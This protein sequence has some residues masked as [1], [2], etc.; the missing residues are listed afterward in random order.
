MLPFAPNTDGRVLLIGWDAVDWGA[1][2]STVADDLTPHLAR[3]RAAGTFGRL[4]PVRPLVAPMLWTSLA[5]GTRADKHGV[6]GFCEPLPDGRGIIP[7]RSTRRRRPAIWDYATAAGVPSHVVGWPVTAPADAVRGVMVSDGYFR[8]E[9]STDDEGVADDAVTVHPE[10]QAIADAALRRNTPDHMPSDEHRSAAKQLLDGSSGD[11]RWGGS[12]AAGLSQLQSLHAIAFSLLSAGHWQFAAVRYPTAAA[13]LPGDARDE[14]HHAAW[15]LQD[16]MLGELVR[17][18]GAETTVILVSPARMSRLSVGASHPADQFQAN[19][20]NA[21]GM[22]CVTGP[23]VIAA[24]RLIGATVLDVAP[25]VLDRLGF[26]LPGDLDGRPWLHAFAPRDAGF[27]R[28]AAVP[29]ARFAG[30]ALEAAAADSERAASESPASTCGVE[31]DDSSGRQACAQVLHNHKVN[32]AEALADSDRFEQALR[33]WR[34]L[35]TSHPEDPQFAVQLVRALLRGGRHG[36]CAEVIAQLPPA[37]QTLWPVQLG[38]AEIAAAKQRTGEAVALA[39][40]VVERGSSPAA[41]LAAA[42]IL[43]NC[44]AWADAESAYQRHLDAH[45][46]SAAAYG[47]LARA[48]WQQER[49]ELAREA[50]QAALAL[51]PGYTEA[52]LHMALALRELDRQDD[53]IREFERCV[54]E[55]W[56]IEVAHGQLA[57]LYCTRSPRRAAMHRALA[58]VG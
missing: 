58:G 17:I 4:A 22:A 8:G 47:G 6:L 23:E 36:E 15:R 43:E 14:L 33:L 1:V 41:L 5:T 3:M 10:Y 11:T 49:P 16:A 9:R 13:L 20:E 40:S 44:Q 7:V 30:D 12:V 19:S 50:A 38:E 55:Q 39:C 34:E 18:V 37:M 51:A 24:D 25:T 32:L 56:Q 57:S 52:R 46:P 53:A 28:V 2:N 35:A 48:S 31:A 26:D 42:K 21:L 27:R 45:G 29:A 54:E